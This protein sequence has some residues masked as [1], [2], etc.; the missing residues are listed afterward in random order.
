MPEMRSY[1]AD[2]AS[3]SRAYS[4]SSWTL[5]AMASLFTGRVPTDLRL[6]DGTLIALA[7]GEATL[8]RSLAERGFHTVAVSANYTVNHENGFSEGFDLFLAP[9]VL[10]PG[11]W[12]DVTWVLERARQALRWLGDRDLFLYLHVMDPH[13][14]YRNHETGDVFVAPSTGQDVDAGTLA[15]MR[16]AYASEVARTS[17]LLAPFFAAAEPLDLAI[18]TADHGEEFGEHGGFKHGPT[19]YPEVSRVPLL[20]RGKG[21]DPGVWSHPVSL[22]GLAALI[23]AGDRGLFAPRED[24]EGLEGVTVETFAHAPPRW[25]WV[26]GEGEVILFARRLG[27]EKPGEDPIGEWLAAHH[28]RLA[29]LDAAGAPREGDPGE[30]RAAAQR[31]VD[32]FQGL[33]RGLWIW[34]PAAT[35]H[36]ALEVA[37]AS[38]SGWWWG[39]AR[40]AR[41]RARED[42]QALLEVEAPRPF[43]LVFLDTAGEQAGLPAGGAALLDAAPARLPGDR[44]VAWLDPGRPEAATR[45]VEET[46]ERL[47]NLGYL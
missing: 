13:D 8:A 44:V 28:P 46:M 22:A 47:R 25:A 23:A 39:E 37:G 12:P 38:G 20:L 29:Y 32:Q 34:F 21:V 11:A 16:A 42:G 27:R 41:L 2:G 36:H 45:G 31:L 15:E 19:V 35:R 3:F 9:A 17:R 7:P 43:S 26:H 4:A 1:F 14:P 40:A 18:L 30:A 6:A 33:R 24:V 10:E 5:P